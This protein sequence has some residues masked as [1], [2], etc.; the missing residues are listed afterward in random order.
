MGQKRK[1]VG[2]R[3]R[4]GRAYLRLEK[5]V[6][7]LETS[8]LDRKEAGLFVCKADALNRLVQCSKTWTDHAKIVRVYRKVRR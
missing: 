4:Y 8:T 2:Y 7:G 3:V 5:P 6:I 1:V